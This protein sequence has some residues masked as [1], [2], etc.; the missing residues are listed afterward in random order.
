MDKTEEK[1]KFEKNKNE[2][3]KLIISKRKNQAWIK[4]YRIVL[5]I[6]FVISGFLFMVLLMDSHYKALAIEQ[7]NSAAKAVSDDNL[8]KVVTFFVDKY[9]IK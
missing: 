7:I 6:L 1:K 4:N 3:R 5:G 2:I 9:N 8:R